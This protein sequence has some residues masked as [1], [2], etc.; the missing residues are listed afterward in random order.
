MSTLVTNGTSVMRP[1]KWKS[2]AARRICRF[3]GLAH[4]ED[5]VVEVARRLLDGV[6]TCPTDLDAIFSRLDIEECIIDPDMLVSGELRRGD[7]GFVVACSPHEPQ[8]RRRFTIAHEL[9]HAFFEKTGPYVPHHGRELECICDRIATEI[10]IPQAELHKAVR[11]P[12]TLREV[13][14]LAKMFDASITTTALRC[15]DLFDVTVGQFE[16]DEISWLFTPSGVPRRTLRS[17]MLTLVKQFATTDTGE[18]E[19][20][21][22]IGKNDERTMY[23]QWRSTGRHGRKL[24]LLSAHSDSPSSLD[25]NWTLDEDESPSYVPSVSHRRQLEFSSLPSPADDEST[26]SAEPEAPAYR[27]TSIA[28]RL[29]EH[30]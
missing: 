11:A 18:V 20:L 8:R 5:A 1:R 23:L 9:G 30:I 7:Q 22:L 27:E 2:A 26:V 29:V 6:Q 16:D 10:L 19:C 13:G 28:S 4:V 3:T 21:A 14:R 15:W 12:V 24:L 25:S 17:Q